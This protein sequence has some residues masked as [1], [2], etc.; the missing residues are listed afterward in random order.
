MVGQPRPRGAVRGVVGSV[1]PISRLDF[2]TIPCASRCRRSGK[3]AARIS[4]SRAFCGDTLAG[5]L[6]TPDGKQLA[7]SGIAPSLRAGT[8]VELSPQPLQ[9]DGPDGWHAVGARISGRQSPACYQYAA[10]RQP[11]DGCELWRLQA[12]PGVRYPA[13]GNSGVYLRGRYE[14]QI[15]DSA[16]HEVSTGGSARS[17]ASSFP[18]RSGE[19]AG[20]W[21]T[22]DIT[23]VGRR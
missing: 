15:E 9:R 10:R 16:A 6:T 8:P 22:Y 17:T 4:R 21:Q 14:A 1:R 12:P 2:S 3:G 5:S 11:R 23:L 20:E 13:A 18:T 7:W 19:G